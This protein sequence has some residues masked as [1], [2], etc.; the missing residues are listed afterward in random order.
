MTLRSF[1]YA[2]SQMR[3]V[4]HLMINWWFHLPHKK[5]RFKCLNQWGSLS[6]KSPLPFFMRSVILLPI[7]FQGFIVYPQFVDASV[8]FSIFQ[9]NAILVLKIF[10][11]L[12]ISLTKSNVKV[13]INYCW[14]YI[15]TSLF[16]DIF[17]ASF[18]KF[19]ANSISRS[20]K[21][22]AKSCFFLRS[23]PIT[24]FNVFSRHN[25]QTR[26]CCSQ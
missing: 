11:L 8:Q 14:I 22:S 9:N 7:L 24:F 26:F 19:S 16:E 5:T 25:F 12:L 15:K 2:H 21:I 4:L 13:F 3:C 23:A 1:H 18:S 17:H 6:S 10:L 20:D